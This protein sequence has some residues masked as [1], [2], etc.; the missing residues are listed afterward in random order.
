MKSKTTAYILWCGGFFGLCG[1]H[2]F[3]IGKVGT[4]LL[5]LFTL[6]LLG[7]G[8]LIDL[9]TLGGQVDEVNVKRGYGPAGQSNTQKSNQNVVVNVQAPSGSSGDES[10]SSGTEEEN[11]ADQ[12][13]RL[14]KMLEEGHITEEELK[15]QKEKLFNS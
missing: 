2:R 4:G 13:E 10:G 11:K 1:L 3:Y 14:T 7:I 6:G 9:F 15:K 12:L 8:Q 5:W